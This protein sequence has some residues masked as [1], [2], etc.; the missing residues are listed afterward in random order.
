MVKYF[1]EAAEMYA[2]QF[3]MQ[4]ETEAKPEPVLIGVLSRPYGYIGFDPIPKGT[5][6]FRQEDRDYFEMRHTQ[7]GQ[8]IQQRFYKDGLKDHLI[9]IED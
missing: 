6:V 3:K 2:G 1:D 8:V 7:S 4:E 9:P 5:Q